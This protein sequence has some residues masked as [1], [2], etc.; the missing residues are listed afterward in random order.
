MINVVEPFL[1]DVSNYN[2]YVEEIYSRKWLTNNGPL[3]QKLTSRL[4][5]H[6]EIK[7]LLLVSNGTVAIQLAL[8]LLNCQKNIITT[9]FSF[10]A[11][12]NA[13]L[14]GGC[15]VTFADIQAN[16]FNISPKEIERKI[17]PDTECIIPVHVFGNPCDVEEIEKVSKKHNVK[18]IYDA[19]HAF[20]VKCNGKSVL[21]YGDISTL[22]FHATKI[23]HSVEGGALVINDDELYKKAVSLINFGFQSG[24]LLDVGINAKMSEFHA[25]MGLCVLDEIDH[26][27]SRRKVIY[28][29]YVQ[30]LAGVV[31]FQK[32]TGDVEYNYSYF[33]ILLEN[34]KELLCLEKTLTANDIFPRR[35]FYPSLNTLSYIK[36]ME[37]MPVSEDVA[38]RILC[39]PIYPALSDEQ[40]TK[41]INV[42][43]SSNKIPVVRSQS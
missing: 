37:E 13:P 22:S 38:G 14:W 36:S 27:V 19:A 26:I 15:D 34:E 35:Y 28:K 33:P 23:F 32:L 16:K 20:G 9:P 31:G 17:Q 42:I 25:A 12:V 24:E 21:R 3:V 7:N 43:K 1:P 39:L 30:E 10:V 29:R 5:K 41:I 6:L 2:R 4:E 11:T 8:K 40:Q 18:V